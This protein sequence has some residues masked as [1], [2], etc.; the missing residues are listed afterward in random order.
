MKRKVL[1]RFLAASMA[2]IMAVGMAGC[3]NN[4]DASGSGSSDSG[5]GSSESTPDSGSQPGSTTPDVEEYTVLKDADGNVYDL[6]GITVEIRDWF[7]PAEPKEPVDDYEEAR[8]AYREW[9]QKTYNFTVKE[10]AMGDWGSNHQDYQDYVTGNGDDH[11]YVFCLHD[12]GAVLTM[13]Q[14][15]LMYD[16]ST[17]DCLDFSK[18]SYQ[19]SKTHELYTDVST[20]AIYAMR[21]MVVEPRQGIYFNKRILEE[22]GIDWKEIYKAV[23]DGTWTWAKFEDYCRQIHA[24]T[25]ADG[26][27]DRWALVGE[28]SEIKNNYV[29]SNHA[30]YIGFENGKYVNKT[31]DPATLE[32]LNEALRMMSLYL[33]K[34]ADAAWDWFV[35]A[36]NDGLVGF[37]I[38]AAYRAGQ[39][40][41]SGQVAEDGFGF[42][43]FP[44]SPNVSTYR[45]FASD[46]I[47]IIPSCYDAEKAWKCA[48]AFDQW[49]ATIPGYEGYNELMSGYYANFADSESVDIGIK[50]VSEY[51]VKNN[52]SVIPGLDFGNDYL[53]QIND[54][55]T[56]Q[57]AAEACRDKWNQLIDA[58]NEGSLSK[59]Q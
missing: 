29:V 5:S 57:Q 42:V 53:W 56:P 24:D 41:A 11:Y 59:G 20:G 30:E 33:Y 3:G 55:N 31:E 23:Q 32:G 37:C 9:A 4:D 18:E 14:N 38:D 6:G 45:S 15:H 10:V 36:F 39:T 19:K 2:T 28:E 40:Y 16:L 26:E 47:Y 50:T 52:H 43:P 8:D 51:A 35:P 54:S 7:A 58:A 46:N 48:F 44:K 13:M 1:S 49:N 21:P 34:P 17:L 22:A 12:G 25:D 27:I